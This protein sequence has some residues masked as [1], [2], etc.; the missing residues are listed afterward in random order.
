MKNYDIC[1]SRE[2]SFSDARLS[3]I[4]SVD[5]VFS[6]MEKNLRTDDNGFLGLSITQLEALW[7]TKVLRKIGVEAYPICNKYR[8]SSLRKDE[9]RDIAKNHLVKIQKETVGFDFQELQDAPAAWWIDKIAFCFFSKSEKMAL[10][11]ISPP[12]V[13]VC[14]DRMNFT[15][16]E[17]EDLLYA[18]LPIMLIE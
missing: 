5:P 2:F 17:K 10:D 1:C 9:A 13:I 18:E 4:F 8:L 12:G 15:V 6:S 7:V 3:R 16:M 14:V 11:D